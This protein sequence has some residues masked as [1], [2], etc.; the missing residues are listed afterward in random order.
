MWELPS[1]AYI[2]FYFVPRLSRAQSS[3]NLYLWINVIS[4]DCLCS[5]RLIHNW[6]SWHGCKHDWWHYHRIIVCLCGVCTI[7]YAWCWVWWYCLKVH[8]KRV[9][10]NVHRHGVTWDGD[11]IVWYRNIHGWHILTHYLLND[12]HPSLLLHCLFS[13]AWFTRLMSCYFS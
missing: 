2:S 7:H 9:I 10:V 8:C 1:R 4:Y 6:E 13:R 5:R 12:W 3:K 11:D